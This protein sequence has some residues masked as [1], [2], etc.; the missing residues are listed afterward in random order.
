MNQNER[1]LLIAR[2]CSGSIRVKVRGEVYTIKRPTPEQLYVGQEVFFDYFSA[3]QEA[4]LYSDSELLG[5]LFKSGFWDMKRNALLESL[6]KE[7][8]QFKV[9]LFRSQFKSKQIEVIRKA[10][11]TAKAKLAELNSQRFEY[12]YLSC[13]GVASLA[14]SKYLI[15]ASTYHNGKPA[16]DDVWS[17]DSEKLDEIMLEC[18]RKRI[19]ESQYREV[20]RT[21]PWRSIWGP[22]KIESSLFGVP[23]AE[24]TEEQRHLVG[25]SIHYDN[26]Y[27][28][29][30]CPT[31]DV[32]NDDDTLD[33]WA[34]EQKRLRD[35]QIAGGVGEELIKNEKIRNSQEVYLFAD[36]HD[37]ARKIDALNSDAAISTKKKRFQALAKHGTLSELEMPDTSR[38][39]RM[40][41]MKRLQDNMKST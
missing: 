18:S 40:E 16:F 8:D 22:H 32:I 25:W 15:G 6:P 23:A 20:A 2:I 26:I 17:G 30:N 41:V 33:G 3:A 27:Q 35:A 14:R 21:D 5:W 13:S 31:D 37:D 7:I 11:A 39:L 24:Y 36:T 34:I 4:G 9:A 1:D 29:P 19:V 10:L 38:R 28:H 12:D